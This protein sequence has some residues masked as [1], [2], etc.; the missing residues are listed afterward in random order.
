[1][2]LSQ[3]RLV[4]ES[5]VADRLSGW[6]FSHILVRDAAY[7]GLLKRDRSALHE[8]C[9]DWITTWEAGHELA[10]IAAY[11]REQAYVY[12]AELGVV[13]QRLRRL[14]SRAVDDLATSGRRALRQG[15]LASA[16]GWL[17]RA[18]TVADDADPRR[19]GLLTD[20]GTALS[21]LGERERARRV[22]EEAMALAAEAGDVS[23]RWR[24]RRPLLE[25]DAS[26]DQMVAEARE[27]LDLLGSLGDDAG[28]ARA[29]RIIA[30]AAWH[31][32]RIEES[33]D[34]TRVALSHAL[35]A[36]EEAEARDIRAALP[37]LAMEGT[38]P[39]PQ[40]LLLARE[41]L[42]E[43]GDSFRARGF[44]LLSMAELLLMD[45]DPRAAR[46]AWAEADA[47]LREGGIQRW[48]YSL[49]R[50]LAD[51]DVADGHLD[52]AVATLA[53]CTD[54]TS[55]A[56][57]IRGWIAAHLVHVLLDMNRQPE[58]SAHAELVTQTDRQIPGD[59]TL[60]ASALARLAAHQGDRE[61]ATRMAQ[62]AV[63][64][65]EGTD[66]LDHRA[67]ALE[68]SAEVTRAL[69]DVDA[70]VTHLREA[71]KLFDLKHDRRAARRVRTALASLDADESGDR[72]R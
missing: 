39:V 12:A 15:S 63:D 2:R 67:L 64:V 41:T 59:W 55:L 60:A 8:R 34:T 9:A 26:G 31:R 25:F 61:D 72:T 57:D 45:D 20:L 42:L 1:M 47:A 18:L 46:Q 27:H 37:A 58:A 5:G 49:A 28:L 43:V 52:A 10:D 36:E 4:T 30:L 65:L 70:S 14:Q 40:A 11:H 53:T 13:D 3:A 56:P 23:A 35:A 33:L 68:R 66:L 6:S 69:G 7:A 29:W 24:A 54:D 62:E 50:I 21:E 71:L 32:G 22:L 38:T 17:E 44:V 19:T 48:D 51:I 16:S